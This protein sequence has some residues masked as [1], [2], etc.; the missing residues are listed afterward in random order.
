LTANPDPKPR[1]KTQPHPFSPVAPGTFTIPLRNSLSLPISTFPYTGEAET[2]LVDDVLLGAG[3]A[4]V[5][6]ETLRENL[7]LAFVGFAP[8]LTEGG[9]WHQTKPTA[10]VALAK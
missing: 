5:L 8:G 6:G 10:N 9:F 3:R 7:L 4:R 2:A 1:P